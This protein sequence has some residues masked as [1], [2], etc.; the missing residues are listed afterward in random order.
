M[1]HLIFLMLLV[2]FTVMAQITLQG[3]DSVTETYYCEPSTGECPVPEV[4]VAYAHGGDHKRMTKEAQD[5]RTCHGSDLQ[6]TSKSIAEFARTCIAPDKFQMPDN[7]M[8]NERWITTWPDGELFN[9]VDSKTARVEVGDIVGCQ[10]CHDEVKFE[11]SRG[12]KIE[13][14]VREDD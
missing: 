3:G 1:K 6:G 11:D 10:M 8:S 12:N 13:M 2:P 7:A 9:I 14:H 4:D 5:C